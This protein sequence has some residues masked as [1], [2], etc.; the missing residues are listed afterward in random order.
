MN[1]KTTRIRELVGLLN[2]AGNAYYNEDREIMSNYEYDALYSELEAL[3][4]ETGIV[5]ADSPTVHVGYE[6]RDVLPKV[7]FDSP[8]LSLDKTKSVDTLAEFVG[9]HKAVMSWKMDGLT[10]VL[11]YEGGELKSAVTRGNGTV[12]ELVTPNARTFKNLPVRIPYRGTLVLRGEAVIHYSDFERINSAIEDVE[13]RYKNP[14][15]LCSGS[16][17]QLNPEITAQRQ[18]YFY[19]FALVSA[20]DVDF[21]NSR[22]RQFDWLSEQG[23]TV[24]GHVLVT[25]ETVPDAVREFSSKIEKNDFPSDGLVVLYDDIAYGE[26]LGT[27]AKFPRNAFAFKWQDDTRET[28]LRDIEW[29]PS[30]TG[31]I[32]PI[33]VFDPVELEGTTVKRASLHNVSIV[34]GLK[35]GIGDTVTVYKANMIIPQIADNLTR[36]GNYVL[37]DVCPV[38]GGEARVQSEGP[39]GEEVRTL[40][41]LNPDCQAKKIRAY[42]LFVSRDALNI[43]G[44]SESTLEKLIGQG[45]IHEFADLFRLGRHA[46]E[47]KEMEGFGEQ[48]VTNLLAS[49]DKASDTTLTRVL[50]GLGIPGVGL[51]GAKLLARHFKNDLGALRS[52]GEDELSDIRSIGP[53]LASSIR[54]WFDDPE[55]ARILEDL[56]GEIKLETDDLPEGTDG[57]GGPIA[58]KTFVITGSL[59]H[60]KNR[61]DL[62][63][64]IERGG[65]RVTGSVTAKTDYLIN[66]DSQSASTKNRTAARLGVPVI[67]EELFR[68]MFDNAD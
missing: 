6:V 26:S 20:E 40:H 63:D 13:S 37:P 21:G 57:T 35:L 2:K 68:E 36:S 12:G 3:E 5:L 62:Q 1:D 45:Y 39:K 41:C 28:I 64:V 50:Y 18:V 49:I 31:L 19:A 56:L 10:I 14:R 44:L 55:N 46:D 47:M 4:A 43:E 48:S 7:T 59:M 34:E 27:T 61:R 58:G 24:V 52:A 67:T 33:A 17:R 8:M 38:C 65:G 9:T 11:T 66:N 60:Y 42:D 29:S 53:V 32:N 54:T 15:N 16:V 23:F 25:G 22:L 30:R 51:A